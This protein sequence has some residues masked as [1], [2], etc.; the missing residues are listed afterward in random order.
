MHKGLEVYNRRYLYRKFLQ[1]FQ[2]LL[3]PRHPLQ[4]QNRHH[5]QK[6]HHMAHPRTVEITVNYP[7]RK[8]LNVIFL[9]EGLP[10]GKMRA[11]IEIGDIPIKDHP[12][13]MVLESEIPIFQGAAIKNAVDLK[14]IGKK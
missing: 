4:N 12:K 2:I 3:Y 9:A 5:L 13:I 11:I 14:I 6:T 8:N 10:A 1:T 7:H